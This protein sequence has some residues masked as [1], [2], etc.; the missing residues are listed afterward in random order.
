MHT[1]ACLYSGLF[2]NGILFAMCFLPITIYD[3]VATLFILCHFIQSNASYIHVHCVHILLDVV[4]FHFLLSLF[5]FTFSIF[6][7]F[8]FVLM[9]SKEGR[10]PKKKYFLFHH[11]YIGVEMNGWLFE[12]FVMPMNCDRFDDNDIVAYLL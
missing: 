3:F 5:H 9:V 4:F 10:K 6:F 8:L 2:V 11:C 1:Y 12:W 7:F